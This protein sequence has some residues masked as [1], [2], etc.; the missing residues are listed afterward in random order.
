[1]PF[2]PMFIDLKDRP[3]LIVGGGSVAL[4]KMKK[5][6]PYGGKVSVGGPDILP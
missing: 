6:S 5:L 3:V 2:F 4:R 1:M